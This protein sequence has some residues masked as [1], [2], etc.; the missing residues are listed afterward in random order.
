MTFVEL[1]H[2]ADVM[3]R[4]S[5]PSYEELFTEAARALMTVMYGVTAEGTACC[6]VSVDSADPEGLIHDFLSEVLFLSEV[7]SIVFFAGTIRIRDNTIR[8]TLCGETFD[9]A[10]HRGGSEVKG[11]SYSGLKIV[12]EHENY[13]LDVIF[14]V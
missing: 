14:D 6:E 8:G 7:N 10:K 12:K 9:P 11:I 1:E 2:T 3:I 4:V 5:A 13:I